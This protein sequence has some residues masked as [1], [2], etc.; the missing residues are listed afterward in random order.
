[1]VLGH[2]TVTAAGHRL[3][4]ESVGA[5]ARLPLWPL[6]LGA[7]VP[8]LIDKPLNNVAG[9]SGRGYG[10][11]LVVQAPAFA[12]AWLLLARHR[13]AVVAVA[14]GAALHLL[15]DWVHLEALLAPLLGPIPQAPHWGFLENLLDFYRR[16]GPLVWLEVAAL[17]YWLGVAVRGRAAPRAPGLAG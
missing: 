15:Q 2:L 9:L 3:L 1:M 5:V 10:H 7:Y 4:R 17:T 8:D 11:S 14:I 12:L 6:L 16:G 13:R